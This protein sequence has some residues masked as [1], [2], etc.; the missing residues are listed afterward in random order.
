MQA[1]DDADPADREEQQRLV[2]TLTPATVLERPFAVEDVGRDHRDDAGDDLG[3]DRLLFEDRQLQRVE[4][5]RVDHEGRA[6]DDR[7]LDQLVMPQ[8]DVPKGL[9]NAG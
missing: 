4:D 6:A 1:E 9:G 3:R 2:V 7:E 8:S 5:A